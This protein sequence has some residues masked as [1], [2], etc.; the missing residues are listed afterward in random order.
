MHFSPT[1]CVLISFRSKH[2][3]I[4][5]NLY[6]IRKTP[7]VFKLSQ[8]TNR[9]ARVHGRWLNLIKFSV[10]AE[11]VNEDGWNSEDEAITVNFCAYCGV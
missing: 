3:P 11:N 1:F 5:I 9:E 2:F 10:V 6:Y 4:T 7:L 8:N